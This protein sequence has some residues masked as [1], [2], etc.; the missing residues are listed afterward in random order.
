METSAETVEANSESSWI[1]YIASHA[2]K[3]LR[4]LS[5]KLLMRLSNERCRQERVQH[6]APFLAT[7]RNVTGTT[8]Y[9]DAGYVQLS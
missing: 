6:V 7:L 4:S 1:S 8:A 5:R 2:E 3:R 9:V